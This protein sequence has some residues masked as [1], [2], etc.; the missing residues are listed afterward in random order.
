MNLPFFPKIKEIDIAQCLSLAFSHDSKNLI[1]SG[2]S[3]DINVYDVD[4]FEL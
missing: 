4:N 3:C 1:A 2:E